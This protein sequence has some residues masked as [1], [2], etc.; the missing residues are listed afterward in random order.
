YRKLFWQKFEEFE[1][2]LL[3]DDVEYTDVY[4]WENRSSRWYAEVANETDTVF[5]SIVPVNVRR[6]YELLISPRVEVRPGA[7]LQYDLIHRAWPE[8]LAYGIN[9]EED[10]YTATLRGELLEPLT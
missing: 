4:H 9:T 2:D 8:L 3:H 7:Q 6:I 5:D 10:L 1:Y